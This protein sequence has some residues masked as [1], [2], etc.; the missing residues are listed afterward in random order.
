MLDVR[1]CLPFGSGQGG[2]IQGSRLGR[3]MAGYGQTAG[4]AK[5]LA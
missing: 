3:K 2:F 1:W 4:P 5:T